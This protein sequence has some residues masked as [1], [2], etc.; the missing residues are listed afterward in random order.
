MNLPG[1]QIELK[2]LPPVNDAFMTP[3]KVVIALIIIVVLMA[4]ALL[5]LRF[6]IVPNAYKDLSVKSGQAQF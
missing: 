4:F 6:I 3:K 1:D 2:K 5:L